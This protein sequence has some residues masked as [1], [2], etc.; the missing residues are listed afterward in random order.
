MD[1]RVLDP[2]SPISSYLK[3]PYMWNL[4]A[5]G[6]N[7]VNT[8]AN[9]PQCSPSRTSMFTGRYPHQTKAWSNVKSLAATPKSKTATG[10]WDLDKKCLESFDEAL[11]RMWAQDQ[12]VSA[13]FIDT[14]VDAGVKVA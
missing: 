3:M 10:V 7:F 8:Y 4:A 1:G 2:T 6:V 11:C 14:L 12:N 9:S 5:Q 13:T